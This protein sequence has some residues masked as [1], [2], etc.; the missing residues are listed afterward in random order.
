MLEQIA[1]EMKQN[2]LKVKLDIKKGIYPQM[3]DTTKRVAVGDVLCH[4]MFTCDKFP[5]D[6]EIWHL[7]LSTMPYGPVPEETA[8]RVRQAFFGE[9]QSFEMPSILHGKCMKQYLAR[10]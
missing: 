6:K 5:G 4:V 8:Q 9:A 3:S 10:V 2:A 1:A 7:S